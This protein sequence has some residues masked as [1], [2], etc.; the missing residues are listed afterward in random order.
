VQKSTFGVIFFAGF[1]SAC[2]SQPAPL[3]NA[4]TRTDI[5]S[6]GARE[7]S[8]ETPNSAELPSN[9]STDQTRQL[10]VAHDLLGDWIIED[11]DQ[12]GVM[13]NALLSL[14]FNGEG[15]VS[16][17]LGCN[18]VA[19]RFTIDKAGL[20]FG[21][22]VTT[23]KICVSTALMYQE[24]LVLRSLQAMNAVAWSDNGA[25]ILTG[26]EGHRITMRRIA[27]PSAPG[28]AH[29]EISPTPVT[30]RC[31]D[32]VLGIAFEA[33][34]AYLTEANGELIVLKK[35]DQGAG[36]D[37]LVTFTNGRLTVFRQGAT[38]EHVRLARG[39]MAPVECH[40]T[41]G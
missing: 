27:S 7:I 38:G 4:P 14:A 9:A 31:A 6:D 28:M 19:G 20:R 37:N 25:A 15:R 34:A 33:G 21:P 30:Y 32:E 13:D 8:A 26:P 12:R 1:V 40:R 10:S 16:G 23:R 17:Q 18:S 29:G 41:S 3:A 35:N 36:P 5:R 24:A 2:A 39:R 11:V 22:L